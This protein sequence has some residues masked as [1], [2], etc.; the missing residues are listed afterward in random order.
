[1]I[2]ILIV[3]SYKN[4]QHYRWI[5]WIHYH[6]PPVAWNPNAPTTIII[7]MKRH[8]FK[9][10]QNPKFPNRQDS[11]RKGSDRVGGGW[12]P[13]EDSLCV[14]GKDAFVVWGRWS[15][16]MAKRAVSRS[17]RHKGS[18]SLAWTRPRPSRSC[19]LV[20]TRSGFAFFFCSRAFINCLLTVLLFL[21]DSLLQLKLIRSSNLH[22][23]SID[24]GK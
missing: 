24:F 18:F 2:L 16:G 8:L 12:L 6:P 21:R 7:R 17:V 5:T 19:H 10:S 4:K 11:I 9:N 20:P 14:A 3:S 1:M 22:L 23:L 13:V 15:Q